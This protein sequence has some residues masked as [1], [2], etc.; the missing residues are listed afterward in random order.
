MGQS[1]VGRLSGFACPK[2]VALGAW[3]GIMDECWQDW[4]GKSRSADVWDAA[5]D[6]VGSLL[7]V[8]VAQLFWIKR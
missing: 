2:C 4:I 1:R 3:F 8:T 7:G 5:A 6:A